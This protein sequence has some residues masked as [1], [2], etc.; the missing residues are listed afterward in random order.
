MIQEE[1]LIV[2]KGINT[3]FP[4]KYEEKINVY[5]KFEKLLWD[6]EVFNE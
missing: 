3:N 2:I 4:I 6:V 5:K 1:N